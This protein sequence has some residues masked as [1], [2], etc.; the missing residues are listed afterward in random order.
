MIMTDAQAVRI[1]APIKESL[2]KQSY[3]ISAAIGQAVYMGDM[4]GWLIIVGNKHPD[5][6]IEIARSH[7][8][9]RESMRNESDE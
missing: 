8:R 3:Q 6:L 5:E 4:I 2:Q 1:P 7:P 9:I